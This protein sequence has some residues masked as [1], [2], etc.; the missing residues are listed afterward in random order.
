MIKREASRLISTM[1]ENHPLLIIAGPRCAGK[2]ALVK[3]LLAGHTY[4]DL[5]SPNIVKFA[6]NRPMAFFEHYRGDIILDEFR[7]APELFR[8]IRGAAAKRRIVLITSRRPSWRAPRRVTEKSAVGMVTLLPPSI[9]E[10]G[11][12]N[13]CLERDEY[14]YMGFMSGAYMENADPRKAQFDYLTV[15]LQRDIAPLVRVENRETFKR[16]FRLLAER[17]GLALNIGT[18][19]ETVGVP[20]SVLVRWMLLLE[21]HFVI[22]RV[23]VYPNRLRTRTRAI[24]APKFYFTDVGLAAYLLRIQTP[25]QVHRCHAVGNLFENL[26]VA[27]ALKAACNQGRNANM[28]YYRNRD[29]FEIDLILPSGCSVIPIEIKSSSTFNTSFADNIKRFHAFAE[30]ILDGYVVYGG[31]GSDRVSGARYINFRD[32]WEIARG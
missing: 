31:V 9:K 4:I 25:E 23:P 29:G 13:I 28:F 1:A 18:F 14:I 6:R 19:A 24:R 26:V 16:F 22:F 32:V 17:V 10:L 15:L 2:S 3:R 11:V 27:E 12:N 21:A 7:H 20:R 8:Y 30:N 5:E